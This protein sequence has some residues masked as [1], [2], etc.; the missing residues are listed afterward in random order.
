MANFLHILLEP[1]I[2]MTEDLTHASSSQLTQPTVMKTCQQRLRSV[3]TAA[4]A[5]T[6]EAV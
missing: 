1:N 3:H 2:S 6:D 4:A 5:G